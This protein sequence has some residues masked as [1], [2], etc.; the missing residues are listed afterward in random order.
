VDREVDVLAIGAGPANLA[1]AVA[2]EESPSTQLAT[3]T[4]VI[5]R[6]PDV[7]WQ[8]DMLLP[9]VR[10]QV[11]F[12]KDLVTPRNPCSRFSFLKF[13][14]DRG[15]LD[16]FI[17]LATFYPYRTEL[18]DY[19]QWVAES[20]RHVRVQYN[21]HGGHIAARRGAD[22]SI[23]GWTVTTRDGAT[24]SC[25]DLVIGTGRDPFVPE[26]FR[27]LP[28]ERVIHS[29]QYRSRITRLPRD[30][31]HR[32]VVIGGAQSAAE[33]FVAVR[34]DLPKCLPTIV[35]RS[36]GF[37]NY[38]VSKFT[39]EL[40]FPTFV[41]E[42]F[43]APPE[44]KQQILDEMHQTNYAGLAPPFLEQLYSSLYQQRRRN[45]TRS[46]ILALTE[47]LEA[48]M[49]GG[50]IALTLHDRK[51]GNVSQL[52]CDVVLLGSGYQKQMPALVRQ[53]MPEL[54]VDSLRVGRHYRVELAEP[55]R[56]AVY[57]QGVNEATHGIADSLLSVLAH[58]SQ[59]IVDDMLARRIASASDETA[60]EATAGPNGPAA[61]PTAGPNGPATEATAGPNGPAAEITARPN[62]PAAGPAATAAPQP[63]AA[64]RSV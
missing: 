44:A 62:G 2:I 63:V 48:R 3:N 45:D 30:E 61:V 23:H 20:L 22:G 42:F 51:T 43:D 27:S 38:Q 21:T 13:M 34:D 54:G 19:L 35:M 7:K 4:L 53:L 60:T 36:I 1:L 15:Y 33:M 8:R 28:A 47:V 5:E 50:E 14:H 37:Q 26:P 59:D 57:L 11:S 31:Q 58:R 16:E 46:R 32:I 25:R 55:G 18:S 29:S 52:A 39:N 40:Y 9:W 17:N 6:Y 24:I 64:D 12:L 10:A 56:G 49:A 41:N